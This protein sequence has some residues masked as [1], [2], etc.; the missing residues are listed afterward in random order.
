MHKCIYVCVYIYI[1]MCVYLPVYV[2]ICVL[3]CLFV[4]LLRLYVFRMHQRMW[5]F[6]SNISKLSCDSANNQ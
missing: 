4:C 2:C 1:Y 5:A 6:F 3:V